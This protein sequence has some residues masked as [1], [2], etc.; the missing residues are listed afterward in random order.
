M[1]VE[2]SQI[3]EAYRTRVRE[4]VMT[5]TTCLRNENSMEHHLQVLQKFCKE[6]VS[7]LNEVGIKSETRSFP[8]LTTNAREC[9]R[10]SVRRWFT[11]SHAMPMSILCA[12]GARYIVMCKRACVSVHVGMIDK[13]HESGVGWGSI[14][15]LG[16]D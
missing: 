7:D 16:G 3:K 6:N 15:K 12:N 14:C 4:N 8:A 11:L 13:H 2:L 1:E 10:S 5:H 9:L